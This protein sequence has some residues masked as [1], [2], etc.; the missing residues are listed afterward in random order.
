MNQFNFEKLEVYQK[1]LDFSDL[2][3]A[4]T[5]TF[6][7]EELYGLTSQF[8]RAAVSISLNIAEGSGGSKKEFARYLNL[9]SNSL[10]EC[11][12]CVTISKRQGFI[13][14]EQEI[15]LRFSLTEISKMLAGLRKYL[16]Q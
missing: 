10:K 6:P 7:K 1:S 3:Y 15:K 4:I 13:T 12:V 9:A 16:N 11:I 5:K 14:S 2:V 8:R